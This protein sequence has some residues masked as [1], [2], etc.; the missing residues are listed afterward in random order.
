MCA[1][2]TAV[3]A[4]GA[5]TNK[6]EAIGYAIEHPNMQFVPAGTTPSTSGR[7]SLPDMLQPG[8]A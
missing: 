1:C 6:V 2:I 4:L 5:I 8:S 7:T 3:L